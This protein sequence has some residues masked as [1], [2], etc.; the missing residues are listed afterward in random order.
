MMEE[1]NLERE[2]LTSQLTSTSKV[3]ATHHS[4]SDSDVESMP[5][6]TPRHRILEGLME[7]RNLA[8]K[9]LTSQSTSTPKAQAKHFLMSENDLKG[10]PWEP[11]KKRTEKVIIDNIS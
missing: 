7:E 9:S 10:S 6:A 1:R 5:F 2:S 8:E 11:P 4:M 3:Q